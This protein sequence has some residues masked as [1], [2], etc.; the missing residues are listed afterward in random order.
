MLTYTKFNQLL[1]EGIISYIIHIHIIY[2]TP[3]NIYVEM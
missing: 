2:F 1:P 3:L